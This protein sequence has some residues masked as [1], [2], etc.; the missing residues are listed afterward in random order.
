MAAKNQTEKK[1]P[2]GGAR[3]KAGSPRKVGEAD[4]VTTPEVWPTEGG[5][6]VRD[7]KTGALTPVDTG[8][9]Q[10]QEDEDNGA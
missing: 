3:A 8:D 5:S 10:Q 4:G 7:P 1:N 9:E 2:G 6:Y